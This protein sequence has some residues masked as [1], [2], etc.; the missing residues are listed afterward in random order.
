MQNGFHV[1]GHSTTFAQ[2]QQFCVNLRR[3]QLTRF[4]YE[5]AALTNC[6]PAMLHL[7]AGAKGPNMFKLRNFRSLIFDL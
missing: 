3:K 6:L 5:S 2:R 4:D 7:L 1:N